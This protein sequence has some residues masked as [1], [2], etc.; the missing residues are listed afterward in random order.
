MA[1]ICFCESFWRILIRHGG[2]I[3]AIQTRMRSSANGM[4]HGYKEERI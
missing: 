2:N 4:S 3:K 1:V